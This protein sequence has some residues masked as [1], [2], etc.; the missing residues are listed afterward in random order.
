MTRDTAMKIS[1]NTKGFTLIEIVMVLAITGLIVAVAAPQ[2]NKYL[3]YWNMETEAQMIVAKIREVQEKAILGHGSYRLIFDIV[4]DT[5]RVEYFNAAWHEE[6]TI[7]VQGQDVD[8]L[9]TTLPYQDNGTSPPNQTN[10]A[11][12][13]LTFDEFGA[14]SQDT[15]PDPQAEITLSTKDNSRWMVIKISKITGHVTVNTN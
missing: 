3:T 15:F 9:S 7:T 10:P 4:A 6:E 12:Y 11:G 14:T 2:W 1:A 5:Y 13:V 8:L